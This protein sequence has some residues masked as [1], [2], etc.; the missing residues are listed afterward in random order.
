METKDKIYQFNLS[1]KTVRPIADRKADEGDFVGALSLLRSSLSANYSVETL[2]DMALIYSDMEQYELSNQLW[3]EYLS[4]VPKKER[5]V[6][7]EELLLNYYYLGNKSI[8]LHY[9]M[10]KIRLDGFVSDV[11]LDSGIKE[12][13][14]EELSPPP[15]RLV[16]PVG[17]ADYSYELNKGKREFNSGDYDLALETFSSIPKGC[18]QYAESLE[19][20]ALAYYIKGDL[21]EAIK[22]QRE[23]I[24][25][26]GESVLSLS[27]L[28]AMYKAIG[29]EEKSL[30]YYDK[31]KDFSVGDPEEAYRLAFIAFERNDGE[32]AV[33]KMETILEER[34]FDVNMLFFYG[35]GLI[36]CGRYEKA[37]GAL[38][39]AFRINPEE[40]SLKFYID[41]A[42]GLLNGEKQYK[43]YLPIAYRLDYPD[44]V[45]AERLK[46][47]SPLNGE[48]R[49]KAIAF[50]KKKDNSELVEWA[51]KTKN[52][53]LNEAMA[54]GLM[55]LKVPFGDKLLKECLLRVGIDDGLK[56]GIIYYFIANEKKEKI[57]LVSGHRFFSF[58]PKIPP[59]KEQKNGA[60][61]AAA[62]ALAVATLALFGIDGGEKLIKSATDAYENLK[63]YAEEGNFSREELG[64]FITWK[65]EIAPIGDMF[66]IASCY[67]VQKERLNLLDETYNLKNPTE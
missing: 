46:K 3:F 2:K 54:F 18:P 52:P 24:K 63:E 7:Y 61:F 20:T 65:S 42:E 30:Y 12:E 60:I 37:I 11:V 55:Q 4:K 53:E 48:T 22:K 5:G 10:E 15:F 67:G 9:L 6:A 23:F 17:K 35:L 31:A 57:S 66:F 50:V 27:S 1:E 51:L 25:H 39:K 13:L 21:D 26:S 58:K 8:A 33:Q 64:A 14:A 41:L 62:H 34:P 29:N 49:A 16:H 19:E 28:S 47:L 56:R 45:Y 32:F 38:K 36:N 40:L 43:K 44:S 59:F